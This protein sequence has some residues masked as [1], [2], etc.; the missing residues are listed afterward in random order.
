MKS[1]NKRQLARRRFK[2][3]KKYSRKLKKLRKGKYLKFKSI[4]EL[5]KHLER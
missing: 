4:D 5:R 3:K 2:V 1:S